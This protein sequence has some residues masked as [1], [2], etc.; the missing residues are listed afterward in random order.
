[1]YNPKST[2]RI[3]F[4]K[5]FNFKS[6]DHIIPYL[7][8][9]GIETLYAS[10][11]FEASPGSTHGYDVVNPLKIN[12]EIGTEKELLAISKKLKAAG[13]NW[14][15][16]IVPNH[17]AFHADNAWLMDVLKNG[18]KSQYA[19]FFDIDYTEK[20]MVPFLGEDLDNA[21]SNSAIQVTKT[22]QDYALRY[23]DSKWPVNAAGLSF[24]EK[25]GLE[26]IN[27]NQDHLKKL[28]DLQHYRLCNWQE[29]DKKINYRRFFTVN[30]L[31]CLN[32]QNPEAFATYH[33]YILKL[34]EKGIFQGLRIDHI[35]GL[36]DPEAYLGELRK[37]AGDDIYV[38]VEKILARNEE[39]P[40]KWE[41]QG[42]TGYD[43]LAMSN[44]LFTNKT[45]EK[46][47][48]KLYQEVTGKKQDPAKLMHEK[49]TAILYQHMH[50]ELDNL[51]NLFVKSNL[52][53]HERILSV[54]E[55]KIK[56]A[57]GEMLIQMPVYRYY[58]YTFPL[59]AEDSGK[60]KDLLRPVIKNQKLT[61][62]GQLL[63][64]VLLI[65]PNKQDKTYNQKLQ[66]FY[67]RCMQFT[68][69]LMAKGVEDTLMF[70]YN[71][72]VGHSEVG[73]AADAFG[74][75][76]EEFHQN[77]VQ[78]QL[79]WPLSMNG[80]S[81]HDTKRGEDVRA[82]LNVLSDIPER[83]AKVVDELLKLTAS[84]QQKT[85]S[86]KWLH[87]NDIY[88]ILQTILGALTMPGEEED[89]MNDR[90]S[91]YIEK[92]LREAKKRSD[93]AEP[94]EDYENS[95]KDFAQLLMSQGSRGYQ[96]LSGFLKEIADFAVVNS[97]SQLLLKFTC[98][99]IPD[100]YQGTEL[101][102]LSLVDPDNRRAVDYQKRVGFIADLEDSTPKNLWQQRY[103]GKIKLWLTKTLLEIRKGNHALFEKGDYIPL[104]VQ[105][106][107]R[108]NIFAFARKLE[109][110]WI[111]VAV[112]L[113]LASLTQ[114]ISDKPF[115]WLNTEILLPQNAPTSWQELLSAQSAVKDF[116]TEGIQVNQLFTEIPLAIIAL[117]EKKPERSA[118]I[119]MHITSLPSSF[120]IGDLGADAKQ[121]VDFLSASRQR[122]WQI[123]PLNPTKAENGHSPYSSNSAMAG[124]VLL[125]SPRYLKEDGLLTE[126][127]LEKAT[128]PFT[129][130]I[131]F[132]AVEKSKI[133]LLRQAYKRF[134]KSEH[135]ALQMQYQDFCN[136]E[137]DWLDDFAIYAAVK[138][139]HQQLEWYHWPDTYKK[140]DRKTIESFSNTNAQEIDEIKWQ[141]FI[142]Y[143]QW[144][145]L[146]QYANQ[147]GVEMIGDLPFYVDR[148]SV[149]VWAHPELFKL[150]ANL[151]PEKVAGV[152]PDYFNEKGQ[153]WG[154]PVFNWERMKA[155]GFTWWIKRL[156]KNIEL[157]DLIRL[158]HFRAFSSFW[159]IP[160]GDTD[161]TNG[162]WVKGPGAGF[163]ETVKNALG[164]LP[165][166]AEDL[167]EIS[168]DVDLLRKSLRFPG[169]KV[170]QFAF[171]EDLLASPHIPHNFDSTNCIVYS[172]THDN[173]TVKGW[174]ISE[175][176]VKAKERLNLYAGFK[177]NEQ[178]VNE[179]M[180]KTTY[181]S[182]AKTAILPVQDI[183]GLGEDTRM[184]TPGSMERNW[185][186]RLKPEKLTAAL[187]N[188]LKKQTEMYGRSI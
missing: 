17:M 140:K 62:A 180:V 93:W 181:A 179:V 67:Q 63:E 106:K 139:H 33:Q 46:P 90:L 183:L 105:G 185:L 29:T 39:M 152:P 36:Y 124:N 130:Q 43:F 114:T 117:K 116:L 163:F 107:Y 10:P 42:N 136:K 176:N 59:S 24:I 72:F 94:D 25:N 50:G 44:N 74:I 129:D 88:L 79:N 75:T 2:Y 126:N 35:D 148:D 109:Q 49:K 4:N 66:A 91:Q 16:D 132:K 146:K 5:E 147:N 175:M 92:A 100:I 142:F 102:D 137:K 118:G 166:I 73:D 98:P 31:I 153:L 8:N 83:W 113:G 119:L 11:I 21:I 27:K 170:L 40:A 186:W 6:L 18:E 99:G 34:V 110:Q 187:T 157:F 125:I 87:Q 159:E 69:P 145:Q 9:L 53:D 173:N 30:S 108:K 178:N 158:D 165:F 82:R 134:I 14:L 12:P 89:D 138:E 127:E 144:T 1:M 133:K 48:N 111:V 51:F 56:H 120:G 151:N 7:E 156:K 47:F 65:L 28:V 60:I 58:N 101:W 104:T 13:I 115:D 41:A 171:G 45:A 85:P 169:M 167:G 80:S 168:D 37:H 112:P 184:N 150:G 57:L 141:Q 64:E 131:D 81:T 77:M 32:I 177:V 86:F 123:L 121:F 20:L 55:E 52:V 26:Q 22:D 103:S 161:A 3:Q 122:Y 96:I 174:F 71:R 162:K 68:G 182:I 84:L 78:R 149:E 61:E 128:L 188:W 23:G 38:V 143:K 135:Q 19:T 15:Q 155:E 70:T 172:G 154:M 97:L 164:E 95:L 54:G 76:A 160:A